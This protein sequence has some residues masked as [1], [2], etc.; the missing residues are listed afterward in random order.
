VSGGA[1]AYLTHSIYGRNGNEISIN[2]SMDFITGNA[3][4]SISASQTTGTTNTYNTKKGMLASTTGNITGIYDLSGGAWEYVAVFN[5]IDSDEHIGTNGWNGLSKNSASTPYATR[6]TSDTYYPS[7]SNC[8][9]GDA[10][11]EV[12]TDPGNS[13]ASWFGDYS[14]SM[15]PSYPF[16]LRG[17]H[18]NDGIYAGIFYSNR[19]DGHADSYYSFRV[20]LPGL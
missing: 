8:I 10:T 1:V 7:N 4:E 11:Y 9:M 13:T 6:Y 19:S 18:H 17:G 16:F 12:N 3:G 14:D 5:S 20:C 15:D 2:N